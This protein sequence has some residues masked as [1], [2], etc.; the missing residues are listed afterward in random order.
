MTKLDKLD[1]TWANKKGAFW[2]SCEL[3]MGQKKQL[4]QAGMYGKSRSGCVNHPSQRESFTQLFERKNMHPRPRVMHSHEAAID[5][6]SHSVSPSVSKPMAIN[7][8]RA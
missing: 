3:E 6:A 7:H 4:R 2:R 8:D 5:A 1:T